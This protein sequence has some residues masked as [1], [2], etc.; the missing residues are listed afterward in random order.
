MLKELLAESSFSV[1]VAVA[2]VARGFH[3]ALQQIRCLSFAPWKNQRA[4]DVQAVH[5]LG[6]TLR[7]YVTLA[8]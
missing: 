6:D 5:P 3:L 8:F 7:E 2:A 1:S 4:A